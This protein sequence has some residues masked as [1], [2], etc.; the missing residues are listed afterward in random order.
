MYT[1]LSEVIDSAYPDVF[2]PK[3]SVGRYTQVVKTRLLLDEYFNRDKP[4]SIRGQKRD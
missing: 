3:K 2:T 1:I 4:S